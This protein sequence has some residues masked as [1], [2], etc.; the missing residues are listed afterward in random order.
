MVPL[1]PPPLLYSRP[2]N[3]PDFTPS[4]PLFSVIFAALSIY[5]WRLIS[6]PSLWQKW[7]G[8]DFT[9]LA[10]RVL[11]DS[12]LW[13]LVQEPLDHMAKEEACGERRSSS[14]V[15]AQV[16]NHKL[17]PGGGL[18]APL[19]RSLSES[20]WVSSSET[21]GPQKCEKFQK[22]VLFPESL[23]L[24]WFVVQQWPFYIDVSSVAMLRWLQ[25]MI[26][27]ESLT[28]CWAQRIPQ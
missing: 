18:P 19:S 2:C 20:A 25:S 27:V 21:A 13:M 16:A 11:P 10:L 5:R 15:L 28:H 12:A 8:A 7:H 1:R 3:L 14:W 9:V 22:I 24:R 6:I 17:R 4:K 23:S 26:Q